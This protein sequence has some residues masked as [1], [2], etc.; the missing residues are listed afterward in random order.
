MKRTLEEID[1]RQKTTPKAQHYILELGRRNDKAVITEVLVNYYNDAIRSALKHEPNEKL[2]DSLVELVWLTG[3]DED[4]RQYN[5]L[6]YNLPRLRQISLMF[7][8]PWPPKTLNMIDPDMLQR[9][10]KGQPCQPDC[11][12]CFTGAT[13]HA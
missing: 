8:L 4:L 9:M 2:F 11:V 7:L 6:Q 3:S 13:K 10:M 12:R 1:E 5:M